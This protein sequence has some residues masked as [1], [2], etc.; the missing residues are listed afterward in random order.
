MWPPGDT[1]Y[2]DWKVGF[3]QIVRASGPV[4]RY[5]GRTPP[6]GSIVCTVY[7]APSTSLDCL[8][9]AAV[10][11]YGNTR[12]QLFVGSPGSGNMADISMVDFPNI[13]VPLALENKALNV[14]NFLYDFTYQMEFWT[15]LTAMAPTGARTYLGYC[16]WRVRYKG[17][18]VWRAAEPQATN[19]SSFTRLDQ[20]S[21]AFVPGA[22]TDVDLK[23]ILANPSGPLANDAFRPVFRD[24][25]N[26][27]GANFWNH[28]ESGKG[29]SP[30]RRDFW[31]SGLPAYTA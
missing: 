30:I 31:G 24:A 18:F 29:I 23:P 19:W 28:F 7:A 20:A 4:F 26:G 8:T 11:W 5:S 6:E 15:I 14:Y 21:G 1:T 2:I 9:P 22:P 16:H 17:D 25:V 13:A 3:I 27:G 10:P 12:A